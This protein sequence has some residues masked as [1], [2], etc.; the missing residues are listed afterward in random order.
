[1]AANQRDVAMHSFDLTDARKAPKPLLRAIAQHENVWWTLPATNEEIWTQTTTTMEDSDSDP[2][3]NLDE[4]NISAQKPVS[5]T[6]VIETTDVE[7]A[8]SRDDVS[9]LEMANSRDIIP[10]AK[11]AATSEPQ[12]REGP[13]RLRRTPLMYKPATTMCASAQPCAKE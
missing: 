10:Q 8:N 4:P 2:E 7:M 12:R 1:M 11:R 6:A 13:K 9:D 5:E 3:A